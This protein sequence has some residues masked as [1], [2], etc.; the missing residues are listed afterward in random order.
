MKTKDFI[1]IGVFSAI[2][3][4]V[5]FSCGML[6]IINP[7]MMFVGYALGII[8]NG[9][10]I[11][12]LKSRVPALG[13]LALLGLIIGLLMMLTGHPWIVVVLTPMLGFVADLLFKQGRASMRILGYA[14]L[15]VWYVVPWFPVF[16]DPKGYYDYV[17]QAMGT[18]YAERI[19]W[20]LSPWMIIGWGV[21]VFFIGLV[22]GA[23]GN[24]VLKKHFHK[25]GIAK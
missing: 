25:T 21:I 9:V 3:F 23:F 11:M 14:V 20:F 24:S 4:V 8:A 7:L 12:L 16:V 13:A 1:N 2:Y 18:A 5:V 6:G 19:A 15:S 22:G 17:A 10:V